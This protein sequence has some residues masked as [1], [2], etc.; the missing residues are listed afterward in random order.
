LVA[1]AAERE[2]DDSLSSGFVQT[3]IGRGMLR[4]AGNPPRGAGKLP[5]PL[6]LGA[7]RRIA[8]R[9]WCETT[10]PK[11][12]R[13]PVFAVRGRCPRPL[14]DGGVAPVGFRARPGGCQGTPSA[15]GFGKL[16]EPLDGSWDPFAN[17]GVVV[18][19]LRDGDQRDV[20]VGL[21]DECGEGLRLAD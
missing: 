17:H 1:A 20:R 15:P 13:T 11:G 3:V 10:T 19:A 4:H 21:L 16:P 14:D 6:G 7:A 5:A 9:L 12:T 8:V 18:A 2:A